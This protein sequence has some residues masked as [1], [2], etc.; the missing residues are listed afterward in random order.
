MDLDDYQ[1]LA[2]S[3]AVYKASDFPYT[4]VL[5]PTLGMCGESGEVAEKIKKIIRDHNGDFQN[6][7][8]KKA[9]LLEMGDV[10]W[11]LACLA[12]DLNA[13]LADI[14]HMNLEKLASRKQRSQLHGSGD[15]R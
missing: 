3:T 9:I 6:P 5:Y 1:R 2:L 10:L 15:D 11:Y 12:S 4:A 14:A 8:L 7:E 13:S